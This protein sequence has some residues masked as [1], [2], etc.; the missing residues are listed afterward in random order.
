VTAQ[1]AFDRYHRGVFGFVRRLTHQADAAED[2]TQ[3]CFLAYVRAPERFDEAKGSLRTYL[4][5]IARNLALKH[6]R[7]RGAEYRLDGEAGLIAGD[8]RPVIEASAAVERAVAALPMLEKEALILFQYEGLT[9]VEISRVVGAEVGT[10]K[11]R[12]HRARERLRNAL[13]S[14]RRVGEC[15]G[16]E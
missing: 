4:F 3:E 13:A 5:A 6:Y 16:M 15:N 8:P 2:I 7:D 11:G 14:Y 9:L 1:E 12:L 10:V